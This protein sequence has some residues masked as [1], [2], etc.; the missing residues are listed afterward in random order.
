MWYIFKKTF[1]L[2]FWIKLQRVSK[3]LLL[4]FWCA[5]KKV[6]SSLCPRTLGTL[7]AGP[8][9]EGCLRFVDFF[10]LV[11]RVCVVV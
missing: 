1:F 2:A 9:L 6:I 11:E 5:E 4:I 7:C 3:G 8:P 10:G